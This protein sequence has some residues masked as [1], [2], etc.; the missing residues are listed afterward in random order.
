MKKLKKLFVMAIITALILSL[1][2]CGKGEVTQNSKPDETSKP[3]VSTPSDNNTTESKPEEN[4]QEESKP[5]VESKPEENK[6][7]KKT[8]KELIVGKWTAKT[9]IVSD[10]ADAGFNIEGPLEITVILEFTAS[11]TIVE[12]ADK[13]QMSTA[14]RSVLNK[15]MNDA[16]NENNMTVE[17]FEAQIG[18]TLD[19]YIET[20]VT[21]FENSY[22]IAGE[23]EFVEDVLQV[24]F[25]ESE[26]FTKTSYQ[27]INDDT[28]KIITDS[29]ETVY[30]RVK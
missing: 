15:A 8:A 24:K 16:L 10:L 25:D 3:T 30:T 21:A 20:F 18:M 19:E 9:D 11:G 28:L 29:D 26:P 13:N 22:T 5:T 14:L 7:V 12:K 23:Y 4:K 27:F 6:P 1:S 17:D 2:A